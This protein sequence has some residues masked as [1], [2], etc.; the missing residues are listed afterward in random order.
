MTSPGEVR[1]R[2]LTRPSPALLRAGPRAWGPSRRS[3]KSG[4]AQPW[5][6]GAGV[7]VLSKA[8]SQSAGSPVHTPSTSPGWSAR[9]MNEPQQ[10]T[11]ANGDR[12]PQEQKIQ[13]TRTM[14]LG[15]PPRVPMDERSQSSVSSSDDQIPLETKGPITARLPH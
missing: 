9:K 7:D 11:K 2:L 15:Q 10:K 13:A 12:A 5:E 4:P 14:Y 6:P 1:G 8:L 3:G